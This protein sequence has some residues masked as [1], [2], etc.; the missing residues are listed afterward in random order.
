MQDDLVLRLGGGRG[1][2]VGGARPV[3]LTLVEKGGDAQTEGF[4][5]RPAAV[6]KRRIVGG[7]RGEVPLLVG[8][9]ET[10]AVAGRGMSQLVGCTQ[11]AV[12]KGKD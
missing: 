2:W 1:C 12:G 7:G 6:G 5:L 8:G 4:P 11:V 9:V 3:S 10:S